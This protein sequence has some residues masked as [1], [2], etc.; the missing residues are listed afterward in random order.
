MSGWPG[1]EKTERTWTG[2]TVGRRFMGVV[3]TGGTS[4]GDLAYSPEEVARPKGFMEDAIH[5]FQLSLLVGVVGPPGEKQHGKSGRLGFDGSG[6]FPSGHPRHPEIGEN[7]VHGSLR[8]AGE[9]ARA[10]LGLRHHVASRAKKIRKGRPHQGLVV[11][12]QDTARQLL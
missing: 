4:S 7:A 9:A 1:C 3:L 12:D 2:Q 11:D 6:D 5:H 10:T 8:Q